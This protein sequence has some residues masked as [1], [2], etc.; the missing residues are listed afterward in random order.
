MD[1]PITISQAI[2]RAAF[3]RLI[4]TATSKTATDSERIGALQAIGL[5]LLALHDIRRK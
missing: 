3:R 5:V 1:K 4:E 2:A